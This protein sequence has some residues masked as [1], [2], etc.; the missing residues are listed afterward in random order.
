M[1]EC[2]KCSDRSVQ[3]RQGARIYEGMKWGALS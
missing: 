1:V 3:K 2:K